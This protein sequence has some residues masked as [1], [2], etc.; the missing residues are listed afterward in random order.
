MKRFI[1]GLL[2]GLIMGL[3]FSAV[4]ISTADTGDRSSEY[5]FNRIWNSTTNILR[6]TGK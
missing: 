1:S 5:I 2:I 4:K 3:C 6:L